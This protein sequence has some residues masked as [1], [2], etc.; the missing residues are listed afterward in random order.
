MATP[1][2]QCAR[3][4][5]VVT[6]NSTALSQRPVV[7]TSILG[8]GVRR[9]FDAPRDARTNPNSSGRKRD[10]L[11][12]GRRDRRAAFWLWNRSTWP[13]TIVLRYGC[14][15]SDR[16]RPDCVFLEFRELRFFSCA[17]GSGY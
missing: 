9:N 2:Q 7:R 4:L 12:R 17:D 1:D 15:L 5:R 10:V 3:D 11:P 14:G 16:N 6:N 8:R 13:Q